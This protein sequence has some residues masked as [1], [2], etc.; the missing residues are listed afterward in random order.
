MGHLEVA[1]SYLCCYVNTGCYVCVYVCVCVCGVW[2]EGRDS[3]GERTAAVPLLMENRDGSWDL[4][5]KQA[6][7]ATP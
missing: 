3:Q 2:V 6:I 4:W 5:G 7:P 1:L